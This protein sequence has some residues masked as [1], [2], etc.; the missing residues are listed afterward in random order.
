MV[1]G[2]ELQTDTEGIRQLMELDKDKG[3]ILC[4]L[5]TTSCFAPRVYDNVPEIS[6]L[7]KQFNIYHVINNAYGL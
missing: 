5:A 4:V 7:C 6:K 3:E 1:V 2:D